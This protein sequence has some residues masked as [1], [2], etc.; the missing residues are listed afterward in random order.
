MYQYDFWDNK[1]YNSKNSGSCKITNGY[2]MANF[3]WVQDSRHMSGRS[4]DIGEIDYDRN[5]LALFFSLSSKSLVCHGRPVCHGQKKTET[6]IRVGS[7]IWV[8]ESKNGN[9]IVLCV[10]YWQ[11]ITNYEMKSVSASWLSIASSGTGQMFQSCMPFITHT[12][13]WF[14]A[15]GLL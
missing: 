6:L 12:V 8:F 9:P 13:F 4:L 10:E 1:L 2:M 7:L 3:N 14:A 15:V 5:V 11:I